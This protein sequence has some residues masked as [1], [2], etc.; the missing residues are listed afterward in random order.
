MPRSWRNLPELAKLLMV[1]SGWIDDPGEQLRDAGPIYRMPFPNLPWL[2]RNY[3]ADSYIDGFFGE[4]VL[5]TEPRLVRE[6]CSLP[7]DQLDYEA[8]KKFLLYLTGAQGPFTLGGRDHVRMRRAIAA[9]LTPARVESYRERIV[10]L[11]DRRIDELPLGTRVELHDFHTRF[12]QEVILR[13]VFGWDCSDFDELSAALR[14][15][16]DYIES[17]TENGRRL[18]TYMFT[19]MITLRRGKHPAELSARPDMPSRLFARKGY[20]LRKRCDAL[21][22]RKIAELRVRPNDS[23][24]ARLIRYGAGE[25]PAW[26]DKR[27]RDAIA[28]MVLAGHDTSVKSYDWSAQYLMHNA[29]PREKTIAEARAGRTDRYAQAVGMEALRMEPP[30]IA[31][32][33]FPA[34]RDIAV[35]GYRI[36]KGTMIYIPTTAVHYNAELY[37]QPEQF[38]PER[39]LG[40][41]P[42][43]YGFIPFGVGPHRCPG[44]TF[45][46]VE[47]AMVTQRLFGRLD[48]EPCLPAVD[49]ARFTFGSRSRVRGDTEVIV[50]A[51]RAA[52]EV[53][54]YLPTRDQ[55]STPWQD[56]SLSSAPDTRDSA[57]CPYPGASP[58]SL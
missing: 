30:P 2:L 51:R 46:L 26:T 54:R 27:L 37:P 17:E 9:E 53:P 5:I 39:W 45:F 25:S 28:T 23:I 52:N 24:A 1:F 8:F 56:E 18:L 47:S 6:L 14:A 13:V 49:E 50:R 33:P 19:A 20:R 35:G 3:V 22:Y 34:Y 7:A 29:G 58:T 44:S 16:T 32:M 11:L 21:I 10:E 41:T 12:T 4:T 31:A 36:R 55:R 42:D 43:R 15:V 38:R 57:R 40:T 48:L